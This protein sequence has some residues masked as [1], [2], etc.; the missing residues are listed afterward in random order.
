MNTWQAVAYTSAFWMFAVACLCRRLA[1]VHHRHS[2]ICQ[3]VADMLRA[4]ANPE[5]VALA[6]AA[7]NANTRDEYRLAALGR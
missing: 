3:L 2:V 4:G 1:A 6:Q 5:Q 7:E